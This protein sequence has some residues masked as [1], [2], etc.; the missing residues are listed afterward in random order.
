MVKTRI[1]LIS[2]IKEKI[3]DNPLRYTGNIIQLRRWAN[4][5][6]YM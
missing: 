6:K 4:Q 3:N 2:F 5:L 1:L